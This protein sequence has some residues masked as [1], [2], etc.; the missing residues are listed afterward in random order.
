MGPHV[1]HATES[2]RIRDTQ[3]R[4]AEEAATVGEGAERRRRRGA[5][6]GID[7]RE[8]AVDFVKE[9]FI[10]RWGSEG[11]PKCRH[12][13]TVSLLYWYIPTADLPVLLWYVRLWPT[14]EPM[15][16]E[17]MLSPKR[18]KR[19]KKVLYFLNYS[20]SFS[21]LKISPCPFNTLTRGIHLKVNFFL[22]FSK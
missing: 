16:C 21:L 22:F 15:S 17:P 7:E 8:A 2:K 14:W 10:A 1:P 11:H 4:R 19:G 13:S 6:R 3:R 18:I 20:D 9:H 5:Q 12:Y